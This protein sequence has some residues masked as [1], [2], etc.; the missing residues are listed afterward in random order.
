M[1]TTACTSPQS[2][3]CR[4]E[5]ATPPRQVPQSVQGCEAPKSENFPQFL[6]IKAP[7]ERIAWQIF[8]QFSDFVGS[9]MINQVLKFGLFRSSGYGVTGG[10]LNLGGAYSPSFSAHPSGETI[11][12][13]RTRF[14]GARIVRTTCITTPSLVWSDFPRR[15]GSKHSMFLPVVA[16]SAYAGTSVTQRAI[17]KFLTR[18]GDWLNRWGWNLASTKCQI[19]SFGPHPTYVHAKFHPHWCRGGMGPQNWKFYQNFGI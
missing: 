2:V 11:R 16:W 13:M 15:R 8:R 7:Q 12:R 6:N 4:V 10:G 17:L 3:T 5:K 19:F 9:F 1:P 14:R 18:T